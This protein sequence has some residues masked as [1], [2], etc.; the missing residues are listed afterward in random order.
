MHP[1]SEPHRTVATQ[2]PIGSDIDKGIAVKV[3]K[4]NHMRIP[5]E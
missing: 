4:D 3:G 1:A 2:S 5:L